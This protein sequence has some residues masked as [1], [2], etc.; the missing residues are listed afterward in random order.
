MLG[1][2]SARS[3]EPGRGGD[4]V[5]VTS[6]SN[7]CRRHFQWQG[8]RYNC[9]NS[10]TASEVPRGIRHWGSGSD[11]RIYFQKQL[12]L[13]VSDTDDIPNHCGVTRRASHHASCGKPEELLPLHHPIPP[14]VTG[15]ITDR[16][17]SC[18]AYATAPI[19]AGEVL[20]R[21]NPLTVAH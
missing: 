9:T 1:S 13:N 14:V 16:E 19:L 12:E 15:L 2:F 3:L 10:R 20:A 7:N 6:V 8:D 11:S 18:K 5:M 4:S 17:G 21:C